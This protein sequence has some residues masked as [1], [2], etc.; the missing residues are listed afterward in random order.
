MKNA[1]EKAGTT[2]KDAVIDAVKN[3]DFDGVTGH[4]K[5]DDK[6]N[7]VK[8]V[9]VLKIVNGKYTYDSVIQ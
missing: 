5:F 6:N 8:A 1:I 3:S 7:P 2:D 4:L 9:T